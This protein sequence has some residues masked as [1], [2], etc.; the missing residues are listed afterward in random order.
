[1]EII[2]MCLIFHKWGKYKQVI[3]IIKRG[4]SYFPE[5]RLVNER[6]CE[7]CGLMQ[8]KLL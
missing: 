4:Y 6:V 5:E 3:A 2:K 7:R 1:M 8:R